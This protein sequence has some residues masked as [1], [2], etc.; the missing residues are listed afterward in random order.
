[1]VLE[2]ALGNDALSAVIWIFIYFSPFFYFFHGV[3]VCVCVSKSALH[4]PH[5][6]CCSRSAT[7]TAREGGGRS[8]RDVGGLWKAG[9]GSSCP[10]TAE[11]P[12]LGAAAELG[13]PIFGGVHLG[14]MGLFRRRVKAV[15]GKIRDALIPAH[16]SHTARLPWR[17]VG[18]Q[19][20][21]RIQAGT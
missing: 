16:T 2:E 11:I 3:F 20:L 14:G 18:G 7:S 19:D 17:A 15:V 8:T 12:G 21:C 5:P 9:C 4:W 6:G 13:K 10:G 1:M